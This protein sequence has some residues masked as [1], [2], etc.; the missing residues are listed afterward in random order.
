MDHFNEV[1]FLVFLIIHLTGSH[2]DEL[3]LVAFKTQKLL[4]HVEVFKET[5]RVLQEHSKRVPYRLEHF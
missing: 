5:E 4:F 2:V 3:D 1:K